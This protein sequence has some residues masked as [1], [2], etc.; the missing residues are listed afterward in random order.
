MGSGGESRGVVEPLYG[1]WGTSGGEVVATV[2]CKLV[3][4]EMGMCDAGNV[5]DSHPDDRGNCISESV[6]S[7]ASFFFSAT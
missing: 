7:S 6:S 1:M 5:R 3:W 2:V 4:R